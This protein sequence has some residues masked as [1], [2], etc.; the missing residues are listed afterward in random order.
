MFTMALDDSILAS[1]AQDKSTDSVA[2]GI[3]SWLC[4][5]WD[6]PPLY[7]CLYNGFSFFFYS[8]IVSGLYS[9][10]FGQ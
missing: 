10:N 9:V 1:R 6:P 7:P 3:P 4:S 8:V 2:D 5:L